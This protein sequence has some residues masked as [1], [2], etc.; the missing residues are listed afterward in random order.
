MIDR[1]SYSEKTFDEIINVLDKEW[2]DSYNYNYL[3]GN[4]YTQRHFGAGR[5]YYTRGI[6]LE[7]NFSKEEGTI[8]NIYSNFT[9]YEGL[10]TNY[11]SSK[12]I[13]FIDDDFIFKQERDR[14][15]NKI[16]L[17]KYT[18]KFGTLSPNGNYSMISNYD[19]DFCGLWGLFI[20]N[21]KNPR[22]NKEIYID[23]IL[24]SS[25]LWIND[26]YFIFQPLFCGLYVCDITNGVLQEIYPKLG[27]KGEIQINSV[28]NEKIIFDIEY[29]DLE[30]KYNCTKTI[31]YEFDT[32]GI[33]KL[34]NVK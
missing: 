7:F 25:I 18:S 24:N 26:R 27:R 31:K 5:A 20:I 6:E 19:G 3:G 28:D 30:Q 10:K 22:L 8:L 17:D 11:S 12:L 9:D 34:E 23:Y 32:D 1:A 16:N 21:L 29:Y 15:L 14:V 33:I 2:G 13:N 4:K